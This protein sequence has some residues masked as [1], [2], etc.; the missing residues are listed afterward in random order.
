MTFVSKSS[1]ESFR[2]TI[3]RVFKGE[4]FEREEWKYYSAQGEP[5]Y[6]LAKAYPIQAADREANK[7][8]VVVNTDITD[9]KLKMK[10]LER[11]ATETKEKLK[12]MTE[13]YTLL[14]KNLAAYIRKRKEYKEH[15]VG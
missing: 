2:K 15:Q 6:V 5:V 8:C 7:E 1:R 11:D 3:L 4:S 9:I 14:R 10:S 12:S 13:D